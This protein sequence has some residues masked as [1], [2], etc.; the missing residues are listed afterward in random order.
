M[1]CDRQRQFISLHTLKFTFLCIYLILTQSPIVQNRSTPPGCSENNSSTEHR[2]HRP[3]EITSWT[4]RCQSG[5]RMKLIVGVIIGT[6]VFMGTGECFI[7]TKM[8]IYLLFQFWIEWGKVRVP[9]TWFEFLD[10]S[11]ISLKW[12]TGV[13]GGSL[14]WLQ[15]MAPC[16]TRI[17]R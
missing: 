13:E 10:L 2:T 11:C 1:E 16:K 8:C 9:I 12:S 14:C 3:P 5:V 6:F 15:W 4:A 7:I 17:E